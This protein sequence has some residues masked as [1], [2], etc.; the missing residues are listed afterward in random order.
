MSEVEGTTIGQYLTQL[1]ENA[2]LVEA[3]RRN[4]ERAMRDAGLSEANRDLILAGDIKKIREAIQEDP[5]FAG[6]PIA[7]MVWLA[8]MVW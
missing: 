3:Y 7:F 1:S 6:T 8:R 2:D 5:Q 4:P